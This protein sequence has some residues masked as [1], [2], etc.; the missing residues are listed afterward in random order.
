[1]TQ[2]AAQLRGGKPFPVRGRHHAAARRALWA[3]L[4]VVLGGAGM[5]ACNDKPLAKKPGPAASASA[6]GGLSP[7]LAGKVLAKVGDHKITLGEYADTLEQMDQFERL[8]YQ[9]PDRRKQLLDE[10]IK[11]QLL[12]DEARRRG[13]DKE[14]ETKERI[15]QLLRNELLRQVR[16]DLPAPADIPKQE[17]HAYYDS[18]RADFREPE[19][20]R[21]AH[22]AMKD[23]PKAKEVL[24]QALTATPMEWG[25]LVQ[26]HSL[27]APRKPAATAPL[28]LAGDL[29]IVSPPGKGKGDNP[30]VPDPV[31]AAVFKIDK[32][33]DVY[34]QLV[35][36]Q[37]KV[38]IVRMTGKTAARDRTF[39]EA[40]RTIRVALAQKKI[41][42][43]EAKLEKKLRARFPVKIDE[44]AL[45]KI[46]ISH[47]G[48]HA[49]GADGGTPHK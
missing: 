44:A 39:K 34:D 12:A 45:D 37:G 36:V 2:A 33:G 27:D 32:V 31:R 18:H 25:K 41:R 1:M 3:A 4:L 40:E 49:T 9:S 11:V 30:R 43:V 6:A 13:L 19:R 8:R 47:K 48:A 15:R 22:I 21:V 38:Y 17:L 7:E 24:K 5:G 42:D 16:A 23:G 28:E 35:K 14:P 46:S 10:M 20:R 29:G 26:K